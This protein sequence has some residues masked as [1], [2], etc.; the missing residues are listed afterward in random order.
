MTTWQDSRNRITLPYPNTWQLN[1]QAV[2]GMQPYLPGYVFS[3]G[4]PQTSATVDV[5][6]FDNMDAQ[7]AAQTLLNLFQQM[8]GNPQTGN[9]QQIQIAG[10]QTLSIPVTLQGQAGAIVGAMN[11]ITIN[12]GVVAVSVAAP[13]QNSQSASS[14]FGQ[15]LGGI[16]ISG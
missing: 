6:F 3:A 5:V 13:Q 15:I 12:G 9:P 4:D 14:A 7:N 11:F 2:Q 1:T 8:G 16:K 10:K